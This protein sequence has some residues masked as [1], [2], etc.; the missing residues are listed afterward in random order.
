MVAI[1]LSYPKYT[2]CWNVN[3]NKCLVT[4]LTEIASL[5]MEVIQSWM[6]RINN[7]YKS[8]TQLFK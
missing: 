6:Q 5:V 4:I 1:K 8:Q 3:E 7:K 2:W